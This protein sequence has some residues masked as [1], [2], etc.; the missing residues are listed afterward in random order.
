MFN[1]LIEPALYVATQ[2]QVPTNT[3]DF[4]AFWHGM[5]LVITLVQNTTHLHLAEIC[6][7][8]LQLAVTQIQIPIHLQPDTIALYTCSLWNLEQDI[9]SMCNVNAGFKQL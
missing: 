1:L 9:V 3:D 4:K 6:R 5:Q 2:K 8:I 7:E